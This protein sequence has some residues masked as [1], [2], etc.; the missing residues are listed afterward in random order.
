MV[1][2]SAERHEIVDVCQTL[3]QPVVGRDVQH[4]AG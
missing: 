2:T 1:M 3:L 4:G